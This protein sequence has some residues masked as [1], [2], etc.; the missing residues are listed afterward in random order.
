MANRIKVGDTLSVIGLAAE[1][2]AG[3]RIRVR[4]T[5]EVVV[6][7]V[8][9]ETPDNGGT[10]TQITVEQQHQITVEQHQITVEQQ[11]R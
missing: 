2:A 10:T 3:K 5:D 4:N 8:S 1:D 6:V 7:E 9:T 11:R